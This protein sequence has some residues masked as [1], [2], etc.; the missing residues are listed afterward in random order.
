MNQQDRYFVQICPHDSPP[1]GELCQAYAQAA[2]M[3]GFETVTTFLGKPTAEPLDNAIYLKA[4]NVKSARRISQALKAQLPKGIDDTKLSVVLCHRYRSL[5]VAL[6]A[7]LPRRKTVCLAH[8][9]G[10]FDSN[11][12]RWL[13]PLLAKHVHFAGVSNDV[14][15]ELAG[16]T[17]YHMVLPNVLT[18]KTHL[19]REDAR[20]ELG[21]SDDAVV[22]GVVGRLHYKKRPKKALEAVQALRESTP[23]AE[24]VFLGDGERDLLGDVPGWVHLPGNI[25]DASRYMKAFDVLLHV[26][27]VE[28]FGM[29]ILEAMAAGTPSVVGRFPGPE[30]VLGDLGYY[31]DQDDA[32]SF[33]SALQNALSNNDIEGWADQ[34]RERIDKKFSVAVTSKRIAALAEFV[35]EDEN[36]GVGDFS[37]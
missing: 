36:V 6:W 8:E 2:E 25:P 28:S 15:K 3:A 29:V 18:Q 21:L 35:A 20:A 9:Y 27:D 31:A 32:R 17:D 13:R 33:A 19:S 34:A 12:R 7:G 30:Y 37:F 11:M 16:I 1:F 26:G 14:A 22:I 4:D 23:N 5:K 24:L 10:L